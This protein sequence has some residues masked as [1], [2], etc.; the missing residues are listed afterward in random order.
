M[1]P[2]GTSS[3]NIRWQVQLAFVDAVVAHLGTGDVPIVRA[4]WPGEEMELDCIYVAGTSGPERLKTFGQGIGG[5]QTDR[6]EDNFT[7]QVFIQGGDPGGDV[8]TALERASKWYEAV[9]WVVRRD[10]TLGGLAGL[11]YLSAV[12]DLDGPTTFMSR[13]GVFSLYDARLSGL[14]TYA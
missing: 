12:I 6:S 8:R 13:A 11:N 1:P 4:A 9:R 5:A 10:P 2:P 3:E 14:A 7:L